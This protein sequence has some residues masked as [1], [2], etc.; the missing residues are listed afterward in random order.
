MT[1]LIGSPE[2]KRRLKA[3]RLVGKD[4][5]RTWADDTAKIA[6][7]MVPVRTGKTQASIRRRLG[8]QKTATVV[9]FYP[10]NFID[11]GTKAHDIVPKNAKILAFEVEGG[12]TVFAKKVHKRATAGNKFKSRAAHEGLRRNPLSRR[13]IELWNEA[14]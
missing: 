11:A 10:V 2:L 1:R 5:G 13:L 12:R 4:Y 14:A 9:G 8:S 3:I 6:K 7:T